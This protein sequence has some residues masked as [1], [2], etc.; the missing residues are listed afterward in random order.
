MPKTALR[1]RDALG[2]AVRK[3]TVW[4]SG[5]EADVAASPTVTTGTG[6]PTA[7][8]PSGSLYLRTDGANLNQIAYVTQD[9]AGTWLPMLTS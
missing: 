6:A 9:G 4:T 2:I 3:I 8:E 7:S 1:M 5:A